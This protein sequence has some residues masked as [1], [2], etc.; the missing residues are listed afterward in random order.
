MDKKDELIKSIS[1]YYFTIFISLT[2]MQIMMFIT[3]IILKKSAIILHLTPI[4]LLGSLY[5]LFK[6]YCKDEK[7]K[8]ISF[9]LL[10]VSTITF[11]LS[12]LNNGILNI[13][14]KLALKNPALAKESFM[15]IILIDIMVVLFAFAF[16]LN[17]NISQK[18]KSI[19]ETN[20]KDLL[21]KNNKEEEIKPG[22][23]VIGYNLDDKKPVILPLKDRYLH[24]LIIG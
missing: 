3:C 6:D 11:I 9:T 20:T 17:E 4:I 1:K 10:K 8:N 16:L 18:L 5:V 13:F 24:M 7:E 2:F 15:V 12:A 22:D 19:H 21:D 23:A 14:N